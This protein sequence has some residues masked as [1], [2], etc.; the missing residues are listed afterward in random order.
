MPPQ[1]SQPPV[2]PQP[3][4]E[5]HVPPTK[6]HTVAIVSSILVIIVLVGIALVLHSLKV[7][8]ATGS[9]TLLVRAADGS[10]RTVETF[11]L[12]DQSLTPLPGLNAN[13]ISNA[14]QPT[15]LSDGSVIALDPAGV[16]KLLGGPKGTV[17]VLVATPV[18]PHP[19]TSLS[20]WGDGA[21]LAWVAPTDRS[22][23]VFRKT[24]RGIYT[25]MYLNSA[26]TAN[27]LGF[28]ATGSSLVFAHLLDNSTE[29]SMLDFATGNVVQL[30][31]IDGLASIIPTP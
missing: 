21:L 27:S 30:K 10:S 6:H 12:G 16:I 7:P 18:Q 24:D 31:T 22:I 11:S 17:S 8:A 4:I 5:M 25:P 1:G 23:Q 19:S 28:T 9:V 3:I 26:L 15:V 14:T 29:L 20:V 13:N 2:T